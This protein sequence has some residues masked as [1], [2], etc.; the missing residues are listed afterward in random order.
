MLERGWGGEWGEGVGP[1]K[2]ICAWTLHISPYHEYSTCSFQILLM[3][4]NG[5]G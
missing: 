2:G 5:Y 4:P 3:F 1:L